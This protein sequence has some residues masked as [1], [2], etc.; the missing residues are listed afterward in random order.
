MKTLLAAAML[1]LRPAFAEE[2]PPVKES[3][4]SI[5]M[6]GAALMG[7]IMYQQR[8][9]EGAQGKFRDSLSTS[10]QL[11]DPHSQ[12]MALDLFRTAEIEA[13]EGRFADARHHLEILL[14]RYPDSEWSRRGRR[15]L[16]MIPERKRDDEEEGFVAPAPLASSP[17]HF[18]RRI[19]GAHMAERFDEAARQALA[20]RERFP[21][22]PAH[23]EVTLLEGALRLRLG[24]P[25]AAAQ[26]LEALLHNG[27]SELAS[28]ARYLLA[29]AYLQLG[30][31]EQLEALVPAVAPAKA[32][33]RW[34][35]LA[36]VW[37]AAA[38]ARRGRW[39][40]ALSAYRQLAALPWR[41]PALAQARAMLAVALD[42]AGQTRPALEAMR[43]AAQDAERHKLESLAASCRL[44][45]AHLLYKDRRLPEAAAAYR[46]F[47]RR[48]PDHEGRAQAFYQQGLAL[49]RAGKRKAAVD[50]F[51][52][53]LAFHPDTE[54]GPRGHLQL[55]QLYS[56][57]G[58][59]EKAVDHYRAMGQPR[60]GSGGGDAESILLEAQVHYNSRRFA[61]A[62]PLYWRFLEAA[63]RDAR[64]AGVQDLL[65]LAYW[66]GART[67]PELLRAVDLFPDRPLV[68]QIRWDLGG[69]AYKAKDCERAEEQFQRIAS[70]FP[71]AP[72][73]PDALYFQGECRMQREDFRGAADAYR[74]VAQRHPAS[75]YAAQARFRIATALFNDGDF[76]GS[77]RAYAA[78]SRDTSAGKL[79]A[80][81][82]FN[83][84]LSLAKTGGSEA[85]LAAYEDVATR[86]PKYARRSYV[87]LQIGLL[88]QTLGRHGPAADAFVRVKGAD[89]ALALLNAG[90]CR[91]RLRQRQL[92]Q[93]AYE[94]L[95]RLRP[96]NEPS[97]VHGLLRLGLLYELQAKASL[98]RPLYH[99]VLRLSDNP[100]ISD[101]AR[102]RLGAGGEVSLNDAE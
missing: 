35:A 78:L 65:L 20:F 85:T 101:V 38:L 87:W 22:H 2:R 41:S 86:F 43:R 64:A 19:Q 55:G 47:A 81:A 75:R 11:G 24:E 14:N 15:L 26:A 94:E 29:G 96:A 37:R 44:N 48:Y 60:A 58:R 25:A 33:D 27:D 10:L 8:D 16:D 76:D 98:A 61:D 53:L 90:R 74:R 3:W 80:D 92:A 54:F 4:N 89:R 93:A 21:G 68:A 82:A 17:E 9:L 7:E 28:K 62:I 46:D 50:A 18:L 70:D 59:A 57:L 36:Q 88:R 66:N 42:R 95:R 6:E 49:R 39:K 91:E 84:A 79:A 30:E 67:D 34:T 97:R 45:V 23:A 83:R 100:A 77:A 72:F 1:C 12:W 63:P 13:R 99:E 5:K 69:R 31:V 71:K 56:D 52:E 40:E 51:E 73:V 32:R 102:Q